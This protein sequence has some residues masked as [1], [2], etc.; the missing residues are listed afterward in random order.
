MLQK[1]FKASYTM[2]RWKETLF[3]SGFSSTLRLCWNLKQQIFIKL[4]LQLLINLF[5]TTLTRKLSVP[6]L[7]VLAGPAAQLGAEDLG[8][9]G[10]YR[11]Q[12]P[13]NRKEILKR[14]LPC[15]IPTKLLFE[16]HVGNMRGDFKRQ[17]L[18]N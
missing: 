7:S 17:H 15:G 6:G 2:L 3:S 14:L 13:G 5:F 4:F 16:T 12:R 9:E 10:D 11:R 1:H 18:W 8:M